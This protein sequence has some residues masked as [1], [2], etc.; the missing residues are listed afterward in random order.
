MW[1][2]M[3]YDSDGVWPSTGIDNRVFVFGSGGD[4]VYLAW[5][6]DEERWRLWNNLTST[7]LR[8]DDAFLAGDWVHIAITTDG[9]AWSTY[10]NGVLAGS[11]SLGAT[12]PVTYWALG[13][14][15]NGGNF[16]YA[17]YA[18]FDSVLTPEQVAAL[19]HRNAPLSDAGAFDTPGV[20]ILDGRFRIASSTSNTRIEIT[21]EEIAGYGGGGKQFWLQA[22][23]GKAYAGAGNVWLDANGIS[24]EAL[25]SDISDIK[26]YI[27]AVQVSRIRAYQVEDNNF[28]FF[29]TFATSSGKVAVTY[30]RAVGYDSSAYN[31]HVMISSGTAE[32]GPYITNRIGNVAVFDVVNSEAVVKSGSVLHLE[33]YG[34][35]ASPPPAPPAGHVLLWVGTDAVGTYLNIQWSDGVTQQIAF[36][37]GA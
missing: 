13:S 21:P 8:A 23:D 31:A 36:R 19:Y 17:E 3:P 10:L 34:L 1:V 11:A 12:P 9:S 7:A 5:R 15:A 16:T 29:D 24:I 4:Y 20:Y 2:Q 32:H 28:G 37:A 30:I 22:S 27:D 18:V 33:S 26:W 35:Y 14:D 25:G 6:P